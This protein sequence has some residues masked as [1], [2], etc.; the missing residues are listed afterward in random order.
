MS[1]QELRFIWKTARSPVRFLTGG[2]LV[3]GSISN[4]IQQDSQG[5][6]VLARDSDGGEGDRDTM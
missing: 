5:G 1:G 6:G 2:F 3:R 4:G